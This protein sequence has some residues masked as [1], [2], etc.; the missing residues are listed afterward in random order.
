M[1]KRMNHNQKN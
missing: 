1:H